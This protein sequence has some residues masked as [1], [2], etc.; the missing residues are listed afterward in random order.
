[1][2]PQLQAEALVG[3]EPARGRD[4]PALP[5]VAQIGGFDRAAI[6]GLGV[7]VL[8]RL[9][10]D[11]TRILGSLG[12]ASK[13]PSSLRQKLLPICRMMVTSAMATE[14]L[15]ASPTTMSVRLAAGPRLPRIRVPSSVTTSTARVACTVATLSHS[16]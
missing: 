2:R 1:L 7:V 3:L 15:S 12:P 14:M 16:R 5:R 6:V 10:E 13:L 8:L 4:E 11:G 9:V